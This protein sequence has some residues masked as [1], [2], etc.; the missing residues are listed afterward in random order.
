MPSW[1]LRWQKIRRKSKVMIGHEGGVK[2]GRDAEIEEE[3]FAYEATVYEYR[4]N[5]I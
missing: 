5:Q 2:E 4:G 3:K 1:E